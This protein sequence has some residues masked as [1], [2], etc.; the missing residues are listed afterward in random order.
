[1]KTTQNELK[2]GQTVKSY[3]FFSESK[4][5]IVKIERKY[6]EFFKTFQDLV[7]VKFEDNE[8]AEALYKEDILFEK[9]KPWNGHGTFLES[10]E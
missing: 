5:K 1:M 9:P 7:W 3:F 4:G 10:E 2:V 8:R 6:S